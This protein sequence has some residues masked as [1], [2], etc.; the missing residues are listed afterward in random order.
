MRMAAAVAIYDAGDERTMS[1]NPFVQTNRS[2][3]PPNF[4]TCGAIWNRKFC[5]Q[6]VFNAMKEKRIIQVG[7][8]M[9]HPR[10]FE[11]LT[12]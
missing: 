5:P 10:G 6:N 4:W 7:R 3:Q 1:K 8:S 11:P 2:V 9:V 12:P